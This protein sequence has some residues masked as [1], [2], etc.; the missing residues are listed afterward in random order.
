MVAEAHIY[1]FHKCK[2]DQQSALPACRDSARFRE[3]KST[4]ARQLLY[5]KSVLQDSEKKCRVD[6]ILIQSMQGPG[7]RRGGIPITKSSSRRS[8]ASI[9]TI[10]GVP[11]RGI[12][13]S[14][15]VECYQ[16]IGIGPSMYVQ[17]RFFRHPIYVPCIDPYY[18]QNGIAER[19]LSLRIHLSSQNPL[20]VFP[21]PILL[22]PLLPL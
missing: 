11:A 4:Y 6:I 21:S 7:L 20:S 16:S 14:S 22:L 13:T 15:I 3:W 19:H 5:R 8:S 17:Y 10:I 18:L 2:E 1:S 12:R 9:S